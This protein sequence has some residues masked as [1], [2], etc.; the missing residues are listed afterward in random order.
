MSPK[1]ARWP[2]RGRRWWRLRQRRRRRLRRCGRRWLGGWRA[3][4][5]ARRLRRDL[6]VHRRHA[7]RRAQVQ[8]R[9]GGG[10]RRRRHAAHPRGLAAA[11]AQ[12]ER[13]AGGE[14]GEQRHVG[15]AWASAGEQCGLGRCAQPALQDRP[16][17]RLARGRLRVWTRAHHAAARPFR[18]GRV[19]AKT[20][21][22][23]S[24]SRRILSLLAKSVDAAVLRPATFALAQLKRHFDQ[25]Y[26]RAPTQSPNEP[27]SQNTKVRSLPLP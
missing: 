21:R 22:L 11:S 9:R 7:P 10:G 19:V 3:E 13:Q 25:A 8:R 15:R 2:A 18:S 17:G 4:T 12:H 5:L 16:R 24:R 23:L 27:C 1:Q 6:S 26:V 20:A 14:V